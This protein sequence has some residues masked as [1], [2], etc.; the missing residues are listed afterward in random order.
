MIKN[1]K[2]DAEKEIIHSSNEVFN[3]I[4]QNSI[5][6]IENETYTRHTL[7]NTVII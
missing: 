5:L 7:R 1:I 2:D 4:K 6:T 3:N